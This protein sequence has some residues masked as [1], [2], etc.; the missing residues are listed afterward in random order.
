MSN[1]SHLCQCIELD[2]EQ[3]NFNVFIYNIV[4]HNLNKNKVEEVEI[5]VPEIKVII[6]NEIMK[7][8]E[9]K[10]EVKQ[11]VK[12]E[13]KTGPKTPAERQRERRER[14]KNQLGEEEF[15][16]QNQQKMKEYRSKQQKE[17]KNDDSEDVDDDNVSTTSS[18]YNN[19]IL[20]DDNKITCECGICY[21]KSY[22]SRHLNSKAHLEGFKKKQEPQEEEIEINDENDKLKIHKNY[23]RKIKDIDNKTIMLHPKINE[24]YIEI[25]RYINMFVN[26]KS[27]QKQLDK[28]VHLSI[29]EFMDENNIKYKNDYFKEYEYESDSE[30]ESE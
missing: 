19:K 7:K 30:L 27:T 12:K 11:E 21:H 29:K 18:T 10:E 28:N 26:S 23:V 6:K 3:I 8:E 16:K 17:E 15:K 22:K 13:V 1:L 4:Y 24:L 25:D 20:S 14:L 9:V 2:E 5:K